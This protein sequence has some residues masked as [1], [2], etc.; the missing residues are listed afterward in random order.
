MYL[1]L[2][3]SRYQMATRCFKLDELEEDIQLH[4]I[5]GKPIIMDPLE[6]SETFKFRK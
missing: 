1:Q 6:F 5:A 4:F 2:I 3:R